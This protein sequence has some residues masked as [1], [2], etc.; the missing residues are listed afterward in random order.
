MTSY[1]NNI[2]SDYKSAETTC[3]FLHDRNTDRYFNLLTLIELVPEEQD[4]SPLLN[5]EKFKF[6]DRISV[7]KNYSVYI[8]RVIEQPVIDAIKLFENAQGGFELNYKNILNTSIS[9]FL[10][11]ILEQEPPGEYPLLID[12]SEERTIGSILPYRN[13]TFR[14]WTRL[15]RQKCF[16]NRLDKKV[17]NKIL[18]KSSKL[19]EK[20]L[21]FDFSALEEHAGNLYLFGC[22]PYLRNI[23]FS[24]I[25]YNTELLIDFYERIDKSFLD[26]KFILQ[27]K[28]GDNFAFFFENKNTSKA[29]KIKLPNF[30][31][32]LFCT[33]FDKH[34]YPLEIT[35]HHWTNLKF[36][37]Q[38]QQTELTIQ[39]V[40]GSSTSLAKYVDGGGNEIG[41]YDH[42][43]ANYFK[44]QKERKRLSTSRERKEFAFFPGGEDDKEEARTYISEI[45]AKSSR[46]CILLDPYFS[47]HAVFYAYV[48]SRLSV[49]IRILGA[50]FYLKKK[51]DPENKESLTHAEHLLETLNKFRSSIPNQT[52][53]CRVLKGS[54]SSQLHDRYIVSDENVY[55]L[56]S[57]FH[58][59]G[60]RAT[61]IVKVPAPESM[62]AKADEWWQDEFSTDLTE[63]VDY[64]K[65]LNDETEDN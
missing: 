34:G 45:I 32:F 13:T 25:D 4:A 29:M 36:N 33:L 30:P 54:S 23:H 58:E 41:N 27:D 65:N 46:R 44:Y 42:S 26:C 17:K 19:T 10:D 14:V 24:L 60:G 49:P 20:H 16:L 62:I 47:E 51:V 38:L 52:V 7:D 61:T 63:F 18:H 31:N 2:T 64:I 9:I 40:N 28:R 21:G 57:S 48:I 1:F 53:E 11:T 5:D 43:L 22:N 39:H 15:D 37:L 35:S 56:G 59:F 50:A 12:K 3:L 6:L 8:T 55:L